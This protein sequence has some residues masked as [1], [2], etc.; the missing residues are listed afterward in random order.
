MVSSKSNTCTERA[1]VNAAGISGKVTRLTLG[2]LAGLPGNGANGPGRVL[3]SVS[4]D[5]GMDR[6]KSAEGIVGRS[7][8]GIEGPN[9]LNKTSRRWV[10]HWSSKMVENGRNQ[11]AL[12]R[13]SGTRP[14]RVPVPRRLGRPTSRRTRSRARSWKRSLTATTCSVRMNGWCATR[15]QLP[16]SMASG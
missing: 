2:D 14:I 15:V 7:N 1:A 10:T 4:R 12:R 6:Q 5:A 11:R 3:P 8:H 16:G 9:M 13:S